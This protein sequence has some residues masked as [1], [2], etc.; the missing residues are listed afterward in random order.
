M[1][2]TS[3][4][5]VSF[6]GLAHAGWRRLTFERFR[7]GMEVH[8]LQI[9]EAAE[10]SVAVLKYAPGSRVP[11]HRHSGL[12]TIVVLD[13]MQ[14]D[15]NGDYP[16]G[17]VVLNATGSEHSVWSAQGCVVL[18]QWDKPIAFLESAD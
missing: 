14:S 10:P 5:N 17:T 15:E 3:V 18:I 7:P 11:R 6:A 4:S 13:G 16:A 12:E 9:G 8:W 2:R 1:E